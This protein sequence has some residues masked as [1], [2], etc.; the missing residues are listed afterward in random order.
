MATPE[1][2]NL[3]EKQLYVLLDA[4]NIAKLTYGTI[5]TL[6][7]RDDFEAMTCLLARAINQVEDKRHEF[8]AGD[9]H[10]DTCEHCGKAREWRDHANGGRR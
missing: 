6:H 7:G 8:L 4:V 5:H 3:T 10:P 2:A 1:L 9:L